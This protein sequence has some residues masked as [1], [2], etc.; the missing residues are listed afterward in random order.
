[1]LNNLNHN[2]DRG[3]SY[4]ALG[5]LLQASG[6]VNGALWSQSYAYDRYGN[7]TGVTPSGIVNLKGN[8]RILPLH[9]GDSGFLS[10]AHGGR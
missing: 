2:K 4:D 6:G 1:M 9:V 10:T 5:R 8:A 3:Y 7:R